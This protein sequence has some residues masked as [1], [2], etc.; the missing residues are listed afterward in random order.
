MEPNNVRCHRPNLNGNPPAPIIFCRNVDS[1]PTRLQ[2][3]DTLD[4]SGIAGKEV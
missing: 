1:I 4:R 2:G 3:T